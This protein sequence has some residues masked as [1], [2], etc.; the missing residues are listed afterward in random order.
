MKYLN[1]LQFVVYIDFKGAYDT[2]L[3]YNLQRMLLLL[4]YLQLNRSGR[5]GNVGVAD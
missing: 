4:P 5:V 2:F 1:G 3:Q